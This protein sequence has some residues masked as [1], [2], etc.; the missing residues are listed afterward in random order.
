MIVCEGAKTE[1]NYFEDLRKHYELSAIN[2]RIPREEHGSDPVSVV[3][4]A[5]Q[6]YKK[7]KDYDRVYCVIDRDRHT[8]FNEA[9]DKITRIK[10]EG[11]KFHATT[12]IPCFE[13]WL[14]LHFKYTTQPNISCKEIETE[15]KRFLK[16]YKKGDEEIFSKTKGGIEKAIRNASKV[17]KYHRTSRTNN[18]STK[19]HHLV[20]YLINLRKS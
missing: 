14:L 11:V 7:D 1:P 6:E 19:V 9:L 3:D 16:E 12:S 2:I 4:F 5:I 15:L 13:F 18:P 10:F 20:G 8:N 17:E